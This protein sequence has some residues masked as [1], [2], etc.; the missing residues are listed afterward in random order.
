MFSTPSH[1]NILGLIVVKFEN[2]ENFFERLDLI[3]LIKFYR[4]QMLQK[5]G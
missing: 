4:L 2:Y 3:R 5:L 1:R